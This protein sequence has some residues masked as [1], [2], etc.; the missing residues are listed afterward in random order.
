MPPFVPLLTAS[1][2]GIVLAHA[3]FLLITVIVLASRGGE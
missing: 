3:L 2:F 1:A